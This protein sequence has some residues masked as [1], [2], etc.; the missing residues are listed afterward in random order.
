VSVKH[1][2]VVELPVER[3]AAVLIS[4]HYNVQ[5]QI[6][7]ED[8]VEA[9]FVELPPQGDERCFEMR[10]INYKRTRAG[11]LDKSG[12]EPARTEYRWSPSAK[13][14]H[15]KHHG[16]HGERVR[17]QGVTR[18]F[19]QGD[20]T[21]V[22]REV[23]VDIRIPFVGRMIAGIVER[24]FRKAFDRTAEVFPSIAREMEG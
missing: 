13:T 7:R 1:S 16:P 22:E 17:I 14:L 19:A 4:E 8:V 11:G 15:W 3:T 9:N 12:T 24:E 23:S 5:N 10:L 18:L 21:R 6:R 20:R 2:S